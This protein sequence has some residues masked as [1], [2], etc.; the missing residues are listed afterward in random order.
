M[1]GPT[2]KRQGSALNTSLGIADRIDQKIFEAI[3]SRS[4]VYNTSWEDPAVDRQALQL[5]PDDVVLVIT[6]AGCNALDYALMSPRRVHAV[7]ANPRQSALLELK[8]AGIRALEF[9]DYFALFG[10]GQHPHFEAI[11]RD[12]LRGQLSPFARHYWDRRTGWFSPGNAHDSFYYHGLSGIVARAFRGFLKFKPRLRDGLDALTQARSLDQQR[13]IYE[14]RVAPQLWTRTVDWTLSRQFTMSM[15]GVPHP[16]RKEVERQHAG[17]VGGFVRE[18]VEYVMRELPVW[19]NYFWTLYLNG[20]YSRD[21]CPEYL[22]RENFEALKAGL[23]D[24]IAIHT[25]T[26]TD[27]LRATDDRISKFVL[28]DHMDW[29]STY[30]PVALREEWEAILQ[31]ATPDARLIFRSA[32]AWPAYLEAI[33]CDDGRSDRRVI[34]VLRFHPELA[35]RLQM[36]DRVHTYAGFH[37]ADVCA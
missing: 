8:V 16:Q 10:R 4:L 23:V 19:T 21:N 31:R 15:L 6:S 36:Q 1:S 20:S 27:F 14:S 35:S 11:Y 13:E 2:R 17:G 22:K 29:M 32:H 3:Y 28:L 5:K 25:S 37:I 26:V 24:R 30:A 12:A 34:D 7:D 33:R 9:E 18:S